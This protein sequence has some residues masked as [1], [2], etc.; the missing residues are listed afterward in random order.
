MFKSCITYMYLSCVTYI[1][2]RIKASCFQTFKIK[3]QTVSTPTK[4]DS[5]PKTI[6]IFILFTTLL[7]ELISWRFLFRFKLW[8][9]TLFK[10]RNGFDVD[11]LRA[12]I[13]KDT[14]YKRDKLLRDLLN[15]TFLNLQISS[16]NDAALQS[17]TSHIQV[18]RSMV[19]FGQKIS[20]SYRYLFEF[21]H[22]IP[23]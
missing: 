17:S 8:K 21:A 9:N 7:Q 19:A 5:V 11:F 22:L 1:Q 10:T 14:I 3:F 12:T 20:I 16:R 23:V 15:L 13:P 4:Q 2:V 6:G 18:A